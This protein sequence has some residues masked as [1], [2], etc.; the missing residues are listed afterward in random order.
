MANRLVTL[1]LEL[2]HAVASLLLRPD[3]AALA[4]TCKTLNGLLTPIVWGDVELRGTHEGRRLEWELGIDGYND[5]DDDDYDDVSECGY[6]EYPF[7]YI[8]NEPAT[9]KYSQR[10]FDGY[11]PDGIPLGEDKAEI[12]GR[13]ARN[14]NR[15]NLQFG[16]EEKFA[17]VCSITSAP[18]WTQLAQHVQSLCMSIGVDDGV[19]RVLYGLTNLQSLEL[20]GLPLPKVKPCPDSAPKIQMPALTNL[21]LRGYFPVALLKEIL[22][23]NAETITHLNLGLLAF[24]FDDE[25]NSCSLLTGGG[26]EHGDGHNEETFSPWAFHSPLW[27]SDDVARRFVSLTHLHL[28]KP[29]TGHHYL[30]YGSCAKPP[31]PYE[32][33][34][35]DEWTRLVGAT[36]GTLKELILEHRLF[37]DNLTIMDHEPGPERKG[38]HRWRHEPDPGDVLFCQSV[39]SQLLRQSKQFGTLRHLALRGIRMNGISLGG[40]IASPDGGEEQ[41]A[42]MTTTPDVDGNTEND[43]LLR[44]AYPGCDV[45]LEME[46]VYG[47]Y[48]YDGRGYEQWPRSRKEPRQDEGDGLLEDAEYYRDYVQRY[49]PQWR[50]VD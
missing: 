31:S 18:R 6:Y 26:V 44:N 19:I 14:I 13:A 50:I 22:A 1:P 5:S 39:L 15:R 45:K 16:K 34:V 17:R 47:I 11:N 37:V 36:S 9:R 4:R 29:Y 40:P 23:S 49:G 3:Q 24:A 33:L 48:P 46:A 12:V 2:F 35:Y 32:E 10:E 27:L 42:T 8:V 41:A 21:K 20:V 7:L 25:N 38:T 28:V 30:D 43:H